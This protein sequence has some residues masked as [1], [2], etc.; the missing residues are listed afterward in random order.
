MVLVSQLIIVSIVAHGEELSSIAKLLLLCK[1]ESLLVI[2]ITL[3]SARMLQLGRLHNSK[4][5]ARHKAK[6]MQ[7]SGNM[8]IPWWSPPTRRRS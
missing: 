7:E 3:M 4:Y 1:K 2:L 8:R 6:W 5:K